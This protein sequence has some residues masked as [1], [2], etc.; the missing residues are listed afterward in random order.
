MTFEIDRY[1]G[2]P[3]IFITNDGAE[4]SIQGGQPIMDGGLE[5]SVGVSLLTEDGW[6][7]NH[8]IDDLNQHV[9]SNFLKQANEVVTVTMLVNLINAISN[10]LQ[11]MLNTNIVSKVTPKASNPE[12]KL[13]LA[14]VL[15]EPPG[16]DSQELLL[17][18]N[19]N[20][21]IVQKLDPANERSF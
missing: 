10:A 13:I 21:W 11:W 5:N 15:I 14:S 19:G 9:G 18:K 20:N 4:M 7:G 6:Y 16:Q 1:Q 3:K 8:L 12:G 2:D 17:T